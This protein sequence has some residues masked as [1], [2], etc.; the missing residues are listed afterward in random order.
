MG[1]C[2]RQE[3]GIPLALELQVIMSYCVGPLQDQQM[4][5]TTE[6]AL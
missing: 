1:S 6:P 2:L 3:E 4:L 5:P